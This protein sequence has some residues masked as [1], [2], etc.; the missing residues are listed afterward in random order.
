VAKLQANVLTENS[1]VFK[2]LLRVGQV[3]KLLV[4]QELKNF[5]SCCGFSTLYTKINLS[6]FKIRMNSLLNKVFDRM[7]K[8]YCFCCLLVQRSVLKICLVEG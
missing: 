1:S 5:L 2:D 8:S 4:F 6:D 7:C 3:I